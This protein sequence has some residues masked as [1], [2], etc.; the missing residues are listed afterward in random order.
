MSDIIHRL[1]DAVANQIAAGE[2]VQ[3]PASVVKELVEN[4]V[5]AGA[6]NIS[7]FIRDAG[8]T[9]IQVIDDGKGMSENDVMMAFERHA[10]SKIAAADD[11]MTLV[12]MG[13]RGEA[14]PS[15]CA[16]SQVEIRTRTV[17][18]ELGTAL[19]IDCARR[20][21]PEPCVCDAGT[22]IMVKNLF[23][24]VPARRKFL[25]SDTSELAAIMREFERLALVNHRLHLSIDTGGKVLDLRPGS[26]KQRIADIWKNNLNLQLLPV[27]VETSVVK[28]SGFV[29]RPEFA[30]RRN[31]LQYLIANGRNMKHPYFRSAVLSC[32]EQLTAPD[33]QPCYFL[34]FDVDPATIDVNIHPTKNEIKFE[35]EQEIWRILQSAVRAALGKFSAVPSI[36]FEADPLPAT[37]PQTSAPAAP[38]P[39]GL[40]PTYD[41][42]APENNAVAAPPAGPGEFKPVENFAPATHTA[43]TQP[44]KTPR[45]WN[46]LYNDFMEGVKGSDRRRETPRQTTISEPKTL[47][48]QPDVQ[49]ENDSPLFLQQGLK[50][51][52]ATS[53]R[54][55]IIID[56]YRAHLKILY[57]E[58]MEKARQHTAVGQHILFPLILDLE[59]AQTLTLE[60]IEDELQRMGF[61]LTNAGAGRWQIEAVPSQLTDSDPKDLLLKIIDSLQAPDH[62]ASLTTD[63]EPGHDSMSSSAAMTSSEPPMEATLS[64]IAKSLARAAAI[65][66]GRAL[67][68]AEMEQ[69]ASRL[70]RLPDPNFSPDGLP[71]LALL[72]PATML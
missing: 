33:T 21:M 68:Q 39:V 60:G 72:D 1:P 37:P 67:S 47:S 25:R 13:F 45:N 64:K 44:Q 66:G 20:E 26:F 50:Y 54:G 7:L 57:E 71:V 51:I 38:P 2:V 11:L 52:I 29:S 6:R 46:R 32:Y 16:V 28:I 36:D 56:Q 69:I 24:N 43:Y 59:P 65:K 58:F 12:T 18:A 14:L 53:A 9:L 31:P 35:N 8:R 61:V 62:E 40:D 48:K 34:R 4:A 15:I 3:R 10:T 30:R 22:N 63:D 19:R 23:C 17:D 49:Q 27:E 42:F 70:F 5:D 41:P 55:L